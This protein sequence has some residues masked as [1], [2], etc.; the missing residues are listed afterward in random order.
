MAKIVIIGAGSGFGRRLSMDILAREAL[1]QGSISLVDI[2]EESAR[3]VGQWA[4]ALV[5]QLGAPV[6]VKWTTD[7][8]EVLEGA[9]YVVVAISVGGRAYG[10]SPYY[11]EVMIPSEFGVEQS[12][13][14]TVGV[15]GVF[16]ALRTIP[17]MLRICRDM[18]ELCPD[19]L[20]LNYTNPMAMLC[21]AMNEASSI[22]VVGLCHSVQGTAHQLATYIAK[23]Y[24]EMTY[25]VAGIN[26]MGW[27]LRLEWR[28]ED[29][30]PLLYE[31]SE[32]PETR[33]RDAVRFEIFRQFGY[34]VTESSGHMS[35]YVP[36]FRKRPELLEE[37]NLQARRPPK[38]APP[39]R[40]NWQDP[41]F[42]AEVRGE[43]PIELKTS[44]EYAS[45][46]INAIETGE[47]FS[48]N[49]NVPNNGS[50]VNL[51]E[52]CVVEVPC[53]ADSGGVH[54]CV[55][56]ELPTQLAALNLSNIMVQDLAVQAAL[57]GDKEKAIHA[58]MLDP[59]TA[60]VCSLGEIRQMCERL[61]KAERHLLDYLD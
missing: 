22:E 59:L 46:I 29:A 4:A 55:V 11:E 7:R 38:E 31:A 16:R 13:A 49:G 9:D 17:E 37:F 56:G 28:G 35:E 27:F 6:E 42:L 18:E 39:S 48:F 51:P 58:C 60:A 30:Y 45:G 5:R 19:A 33:A 10:G 23:P 25:W 2:N 47:P 54:V 20:M 26:H 57:E 34:F 24:E 44:R 12:V 43:K 53:F 41:D 8:R 36:Y 14:D 3:N 32:D 61:F 15:G 50:I 52:E 40:W 1:R 21:W